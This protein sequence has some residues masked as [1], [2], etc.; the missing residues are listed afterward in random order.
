MALQELPKG[1][2]IDTDSLLRRAL[3]LTTDDELPEA[4]VGLVQRFLRVSDRLGGLHVS[5]GAVS[6]LF[7]AS[8]YDLSKP[9]R[10]EEEKPK[11]G[12]KATE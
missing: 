10:V 9:E 11:R 2:D 6:L 3:A 7:A 8:G 4:A 12:K 1:F 5:P